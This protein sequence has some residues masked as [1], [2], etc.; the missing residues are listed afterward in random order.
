MIKRVLTITIVASIIALIFGCA[1]KSPVMQDGKQVGIFLLSDR[2]TK[3][4]NKEDDRKDRDEIGQF[5]EENLINK[6]KQEGY[7][8]T[9]LQSQNQYIHSPFDYLLNVTINDFRLVSGAARFW[10]GAAAGPDMLKCHYEVSGSDKKML[11]SYDDEDFSIRGWRAS[12]MELNDRLVNKIN[13]KLNVGK[14]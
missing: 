11:L 3:D 10:A 5:M 6:L 13:E 2:G 7:N 14:K 12:S 9:Q 1:A 8:T 4:G